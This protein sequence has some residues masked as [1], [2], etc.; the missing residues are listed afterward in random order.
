MGKFTV[1]TSKV[2]LVKSFKGFTLIELL[3]VIAIISILASILFPVFA[4]ARENARRA[5]CMSNVKQ[6][7]LGFMM[8]TQDYDGRFPYYSGG[9]EMGFVYPYVKN[10]QV[11][12]CPSS[13]LVDQHDT[14]VSSY[15]STDYGMPAS[16][17]SSSW[18]RAIILSGGS[19]Q[20]LSAIPEPSITCLLGETRYASTTLNYGFDRFEAKTF[21]DKGIFNGLPQTERHLGGS[22]YAYV[23][24]HVKWLKKKKR[25]RFLTT[26]MVL[27][28]FGGPTERRAII[29]RITGVVHNK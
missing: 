23:D 22:N 16:Y 27:L 14:D 5:S 28:S 12:R 3:V 11:F 26:K 10:N 25:L 19:P 15:Y 21:P 29:P 4:R 18:P 20:L 9:G 1:G 7:A 2:L 13:G 6:I 8:Y 24:G 17:D